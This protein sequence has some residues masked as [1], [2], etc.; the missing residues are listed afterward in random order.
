MYLFQLP[1]NFNPKNKIKKHSQYNNNNIFNRFQTK[2]IYTQ[3]YIENI[4]HTN[5]NNITTN[6]IEEHYINEIKNYKYTL[7]NL[8][9]VLPKKTKDSSY[10]T[11]EILHLINNHQEQ[12]SI[13]Y[14]P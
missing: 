5:F 1:H 10:T 2:I 3:Q 12:E 6:N 7:K 11:E 13:H 8:L 14:R 4:L 9:Q